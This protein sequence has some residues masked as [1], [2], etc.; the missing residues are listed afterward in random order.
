MIRVIMDDRI[1][2][3]VNFIMPSDA[4]L[5]LSPVIAGGSMLAAYRAIRL[6]N[7][8]EKWEELKRTLERNPSQAK[9]DK[10]GD[11]DV[12]F[13]KNSPIYKHDSKFRWLISDLDTSDDN[14]FAYT[15]A[16]E[17]QANSA[18]MN[19]MGLYKLNKISRWANTFYCNRSTLS[20]PLTREIQFVKKSFNSVE[21]LLASFDFINCSIAWHDG[22]LYYDDRIDDSFN[23]FE[24]RLNNAEAYEKGSVAMKVFNAIRA[25]KYSGRYSID[26]SPELTNYIFNLYFESKNINYES[27][28][29]HVLVLEE[30]YGKTI[31]SVEAL[32][33]MVKRFHSMF[34]DFSKMKFFKKE[35]ALYLV[36]C[37]DRLPG[38]E[39]V[40]G[41][42]KATASRK[43]LE[44]PL[45]HPF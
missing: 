13:L 20:K 1:D 25:F 38:L 43:L 11:I 15:L 14:G 19:K 2:W 40:V 35:Y 37:A 17:N 22:K 31:S 39:E 30:H 10:F 33:G 45:E 5:G 4:I 26:F 3:F 29:N 21:D 16:T 23:A 44:H 12:W 27:Y 42:S 24:L 34:R 9:L 36:D 32:K 6:H 41:V 28:K 8:P 18:T 7:T